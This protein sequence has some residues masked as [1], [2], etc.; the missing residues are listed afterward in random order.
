MIYISD[1]FSGDLKN[2]LYGTSDKTVH[3]NGFEKLSITKLDG[4]SLYIME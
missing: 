3:K 4:I 2:N 1:K